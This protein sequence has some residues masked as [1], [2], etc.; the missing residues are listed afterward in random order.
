MKE[1][2]GEKSSRKGEQR[3]PPGLGEAF[4]LRCGGQG[5]PGGKVKVSRGPKEVRNSRAR[6]SRGPDGGSSDSYAAV[7]AS[8]VAGPCVCVCVCVCARACVRSVASCSLRPFGLWPAR[9]HRTE[10]GVVA[11]PSSQNESSTRAGLSS[12]FCLLTCPRA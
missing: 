2:W 4:C 12:L 9:L 10:H 3:V 5:G 7:A 8:L 11:P 6:S 1:L